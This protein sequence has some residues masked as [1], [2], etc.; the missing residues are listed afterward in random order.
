MSKAQKKFKQK[1]FQHGLDTLVEWVNNKNYNVEFDYC[2][3]DEFRPAEKTIA[4]NTR[5]GIE[6]RLYTLMHECGHLLL[7]VNE[8]RYEKRYPSSAKMSY[9]NSNVKLERSPKYKIDIL[10]EELD[11]W[12]KGKDLA[13]RLD[14]YYNEE[15][16]YN[17]MSKCVYSYVK[18]LA[19]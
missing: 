2:I 14:I 8:K 18:D 15:N 11:A 9:C 10:S 7:Q 19:K 12:R 16:Y 13:N 5:Q 1:I 17:V 3:R 6:N 4:V